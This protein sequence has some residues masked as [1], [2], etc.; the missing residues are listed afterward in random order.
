VKAR[1]W[2]YFMQVLKN[3]R[4]ELWAE[5]HVM[6]HKSKV[7]DPNFGTLSMARS[8]YAA[9]SQGKPAYPHEYLLHVIADYFGTKV[10]VY[11]SEADERHRE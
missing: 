4:H 1:I 5:Y 10:Q 11:T 7:V 6:Q 8:L 3:P 2:T 9:P